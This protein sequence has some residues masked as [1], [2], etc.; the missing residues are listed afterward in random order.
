MIIECWCGPKQKHFKIKVK[1]EW[2]DQRASK[3]AIA[4]AEE[5]GCRE[6]RWERL[7]AG[8]GHYILVKPCT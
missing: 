8:Q 2:D 4:Y 7:K 5:H 6:V 1:P 3:L